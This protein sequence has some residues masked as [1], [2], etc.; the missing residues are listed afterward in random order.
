MA[1]VTPTLTY[2][3]VPFPSVE[4]YVSSL[5]SG[6]PTSMTLYRVADGETQIVRGANRLATTSA[7]SVVDF[8]APF[9]V[10]V[11]YYTEVFNAA[12]T[13]LGLS[14]QATITL[15]VS[16]IWIHDPVDV[17]NAVAVDLG[18]N[19]SI[20]LGSESFSEI[21]R[22]Y[23]YNRSSVIGKRKPIM[24]F[25]GEKAIEGLGLSL[26]TDDAGTLKLEDVLGASPLCVRTPA[27]FTNLPRLMYGVLEGSQS[28]LNWHVNGESNDI[29]RWD[30]TFN[31]TEAQSTGIVI[32]YYTYAYW[33]ARYA[34]YTAA[35]TAYGSGSY[36]NAV[37]NPPA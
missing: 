18:G 11:A 23:V 30:L 6:T 21:K 4:V 1:S 17:T 24:Q 20:V 26:I 13:S 34:T 15:D 8:E 3:S 29:T 22:S 19:G 9:G 14:S 10:P 33:Q 31:E 5:G 2:K 25:Y 37:R 36:I 27:R 12:G 35:G 32:A 16:Q 28:P 7:T